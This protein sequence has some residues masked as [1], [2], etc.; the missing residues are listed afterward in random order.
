MKTP[1]KIYTL[2]E[3]R[4]CLKFQKLPK[5]IREE[6][7]LRDLFMS[8]LSHRVLNKRTRNGPVRMILKEAIAV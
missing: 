6:L 7:Y 1:F 4:N 8:S 5:K 3:K 2:A